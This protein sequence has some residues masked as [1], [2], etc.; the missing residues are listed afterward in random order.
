M[1]LRAVVALCVL[2]SVAHAQDC[3]TL[4]QCSAT[5]LST[6]VRATKPTCVTALQ[7]AVG[8]A[9]DGDFGPN[10]KKAVVKFQATNG[11]VADGVV[12]PKT[13]AVILRKKGCVT[14]PSGCQP[15]I[16]LPAWH[17]GTAEQL[18]CA[19]KAFAKTKSLPLQKQ[20]AYI[21]A[22][23]Q[24]ETGSYTP[25]REGNYLGEPRATAYRKTLRYYPYYGRGYVQLTWDYNYKKYGNLIGCDFLANPDWVLRPDVSL[26]ILVH[27]MSTGGFTGKKL[28][29]YVNSAKTDY[30]NARRVI[31]G[32]DKAST[33]AKLAVAWNTKYSMLC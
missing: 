2:V 28:A 6:A 26:Y 19:V 11:L 3:T 16:A 30:T 31:N 14:T 25:V 22:T 10:T 32:L 7:R 20:W 24:W 18:A 12:G 29:T 23:V 8:A 15:K 13:W 5:T 17:G 21:M 33:I 1:L 27:G 9:A 4:R